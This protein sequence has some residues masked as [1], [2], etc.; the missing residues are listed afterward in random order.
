ME[1]RGV[2]APAILILVQL[3]TAIRVAWD[4]LNEGDELRLRDWIDAHPDYGPIIARA[5]ELAEQERAA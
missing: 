4:C 1:E 5:L 2:S 3:E